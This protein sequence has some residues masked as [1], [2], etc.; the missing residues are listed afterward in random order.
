M[1]DQRSLLVEEHTDRVVVTLNR[2]ERRNA[3]DQGM[4]DELHVVCARLEVAPRILIVTG[5][6]GVFASGADIAELR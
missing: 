2:P 6:G 4:V 3:I 1:S 5:A